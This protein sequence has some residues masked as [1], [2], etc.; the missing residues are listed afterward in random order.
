[1][2]VPNYRLTQL[3]NFIGQRKLKQVGLLACTT[4]AHLLENTLASVTPQMTLPQIP[5]LDR[6]Y[7]IPFTAINPDE[8]YEKE[9]AYEQDPSYNLAVLST[10]NLSSYALVYHALTLP[11]GE[12]LGSNLEENVSDLPIPLGPQNHYALQTTGPLFHYSDPLGIGFSYFYPQVNRQPEALICTECGRIYL[13]HPESH[14]L[15]PLPAFLSY[16]Q[17]ETLKGFVV[18]VYL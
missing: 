17:Q 5:L 7:F 11:S 1:M 16:A 14:T 12:V 15:T 4:C 18:D 10:T 2:I 13:P 8:A 6:N 3:I 9:A